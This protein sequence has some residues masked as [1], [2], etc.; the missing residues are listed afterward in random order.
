VSGHSGFGKDVPDWS[1]MDHVLIPADLEEGEYLLSWR[2]DC[3]ESNQVWENC[4]DMVLTKDA[5]PSTTTPVPSPSPSPSQTC[6]GFTPDAAS[7][8]CYYHGC[9]KG[10]VSACEECCEGCHLSSSSKGTYCME[11]KATMSV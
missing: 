11:D 8:A 2:W 10:E 4:A 6:S 9:K 7:Y 1:I 3:E 5:P